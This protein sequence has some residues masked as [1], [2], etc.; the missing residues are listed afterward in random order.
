MTVQVGAPSGSGGGASLAGPRMI[1]ASSPYPWPYAADFAPGRCALLVLSTDQPSLPS[2][3]PAWPIITGIAASLQ[4]LG[5]VVVDVQ[6]TRPARGSQVAP[7]GAGSGAIVTGV[8]A[9]VSAP[10]WD[11]FFGTG[12]DSL[13]RAGGRDLLVLVGGWLEVGVH[14]TM[15]SANDRGYECLLLPDACV[16]VEEGVR[17]AAVSS[18]EMSGGIFGAVASSTEFRTLLASLIA[19]PDIPLP[20][21]ENAS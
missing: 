8:D 5:G 12:L 7:A 20:S 3:D 2:G 16:A 10:G 4:A 1:P 17:P 19:I 14:S 11:G 15:R 6:T 13:L 9:S 18:I 21:K